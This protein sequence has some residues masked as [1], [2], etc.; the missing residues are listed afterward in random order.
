MARRRTQVDRSFQSGRTHDFCCAPGADALSCGALHPK[1]FRLI[2][3]LILF[4][5]IQALRGER[6]ATESV[7][8]ED[9]R[10]S[11]DRKSFED[12]KT[13]CSRLPSNRS[14]QGRLPSRTLL[15]LRKFSEFETAITAF[16]SGSAHGPMAVR[17]NWVGIAPAPSF[18]DLNAAYFAKP[19]ANV[20]FQP[21]A[22]KVE[23]PP[24]SEVF[25]HADFHGDIRSLMTDLDWLNEHGYL[26]GFQV[27][28]P[29]FYMVFLGDYTDRGAY[30]VEVLYT[31]FRLKSD[32]PD[33]VFLARGNH[34][35][36][37]IQS[38]YGFLS[39]GRAKY[40]AEFDATEVLRAYDFLPVV[41]YLGSGEN[42]IQCNHGGME[43]GYLPA[44]LLAAE[45]PLRFELLGVLKERQFFLK[46][47]DWLTEPGSVDLAKRAYQD[48]VP[49]DPIGPSVLGF[50]WNDFSVLSSEPQFTLDPGRAFV[51]GGQATRFLLEQGSAPQQKLRA[52]FR[53]HQQ[54]SALN[55]MMRRLIACG[56]VFRHWQ[57]N[58]SAALLN[59]PISELASKLESAEERAVLPGSVWTFNVSPD[60]VYG[61]GCNYDFDTFGLL[62]VAP[63]FDDWRLKRVNVTVRQ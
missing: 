37:S 14:L 47:P 34:E 21:F 53:G 63:K 15:P 48:F 19:S 40:G 59:R 55:P 49:E 61:E 44:K 23:I 8:K 45:G 30:G 3:A 13:A 60:S 33:R 42:Y 58:D 32:N 17:T 16:T 25:F 24:E 35:E 52:V 9:A 10:E 26:R 29:N 54:S 7:T 31:L 50:M 6:P 18:Y 46:H 51:Y 22:Q 1:S 38:R 4:L 11:L 36:F 27:A 12:W 20:R 41:I 2:A 43:P 39:E 57:A 28:R 62:K 5:G 56:G